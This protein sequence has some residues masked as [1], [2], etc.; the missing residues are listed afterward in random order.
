LT[1]ADTLGRQ[2]LRL[3]LGSLELAQIHKAALAVLVSTGHPPLDGEVT[4]AGGFYRRALAPLATAAR[5]ARRAKA[6]EKHAH[7]ALRS[8]AAAVTAL[9]QQLQQ[10]TTRRQAA[11]AALKKSQKHH[12]QLLR[13]SRLMQLQLRRLSHQILRA[14]ED[15]RKQISRELRDEISQILT[16]L[17]RIAQEA[18]TN[19]AKHADA[20]QTNVSIQAEPGAICMEISDNGKSF[21]TAAVSGGKRRTRFGIVGMRERAEMVGGTFAIESIRGQGTTVRVQIPIRSGVHKS[22]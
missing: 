13:Q 22:G 9:K 12:E 14:Q 19:V 10:E 16:V 11:E 5:A 21:D 4:R 15:E 2:A 7:E 3:G 20:S 1:L 8:R 18:L 17:Y 6:K